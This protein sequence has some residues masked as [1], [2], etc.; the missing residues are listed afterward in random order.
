MSLIPEQMEVFPE[1]EALTL[2]VARRFVLLAQNAVED[3]GV[4]TVALSGGS[5]PKA[6]Y[7]LIATD[8]AIR[9]Q[10]PW[11]KIQF[12]F[13]DERHVPPDNDRSNFRMAN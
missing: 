9:A 2:A 6:L 8:E 3:H 10:I 1:I 5:T 13:G 7:E 11:S 4:F 12:F